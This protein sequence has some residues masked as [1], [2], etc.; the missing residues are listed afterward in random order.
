M[1]R[2]EKNQGSVL[3]ARL[4]VLDY[5]LAGRTALDVLADLRAQG[6]N[7][8]FAVLSG[9]ASPAEKA[10]C[11]Q[12]GALAVLRK[13]SSLARIAGVLTIRARLAHLSCGTPSLRPR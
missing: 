12:A 9:G 4:I 7:Q 2:K 3:G 13:P 5:H 1:I 6:C 8:P 10:L 11:L